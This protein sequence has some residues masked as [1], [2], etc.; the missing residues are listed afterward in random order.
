M[1]CLLAGVDDLV[2]K[3]ARGVPASDVGEIAGVVLE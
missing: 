2:V 3:N 1:G